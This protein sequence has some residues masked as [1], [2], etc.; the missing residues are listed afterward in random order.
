[1]NIFS[2]TETFLMKE[3]VGRWRPDLLGL[4]Q[5]SAL[6]ADECEALRSALADE[7]VVRGLNRFDSEPTKY[8][9]QVEDLI[10]KVGQVP[11]TT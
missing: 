8:G 1:M 4:L 11:R 6:T 3:I 9:L 10:D 7:L 2:D 5:R